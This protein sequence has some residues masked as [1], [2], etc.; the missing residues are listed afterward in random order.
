MPRPSKRY[1]WPSIIHQTRARTSVSSP[2]LTLI[3]GS[4]RKKIAKAERSEQAGSQR[5][6]G[7]AK[8][9][10]IFITIHKW[11]C[12]CC[13]IFEARRRAEKESISG[14]F[15]A[16]VWA[17]AHWSFNRS[18]RRRSES[19]GSALGTWTKKRKKGQSFSPFDREEWVSQSVSQTPAVSFFAVH[20]V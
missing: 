7:G 13:C 15:W 4:K 14:E 3:E 17:L 2:G 5:V 1:C 18:H 11:S 20:S 12:C 8:V 16:P 6:G 9:N 10:E 19:E